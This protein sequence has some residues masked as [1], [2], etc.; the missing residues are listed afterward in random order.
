MSD[1]CLID[2]SAALQHLHDKIKGIEQ[3]AY[4]QYINAKKQSTVCILLLFNIIAICINR[5]LV[6]N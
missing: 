2:P 1:D 3:Q 4:A 6:G 5:K